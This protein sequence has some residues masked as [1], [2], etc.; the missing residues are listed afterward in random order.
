MVV[1]VGDVLALFQVDCECLHARYEVGVSSCH[2]RQLHGN[3]LCAGLDRNIGAQ[4]KA[5]PSFLF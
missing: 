3:R 4:N 2:C 1:D 5:P